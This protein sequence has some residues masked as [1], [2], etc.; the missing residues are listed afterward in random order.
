MD[1][2]QILDNGILEQY[3]LGELN[4]SE[5]VRIEAAIRRYPDLK[6]AL[7]ELESS[8]EELALENAIEVPDE[9]KI[10]LLNQIKRAHSDI[11][12][13]PQSNNKGFYLSIAASAAAILCIASIYLLVQVN[14]TNK[15]LEIAQENNIELNDN[16][17]SLNEQLVETSKWFEA[18]NDPDSEK[19]ILKGNSLMPNGIIISYVNN[20]KKSILINTEQ[21]PKL[22]AEHDYQMWADVDGAM[23]DMG[24]INKEGSML[25][26]NYIDNAK[27]LNITI[28]PA[29]GNDHPTVSQ[30]VTN[31]YLR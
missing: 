18:I 12:A 20:A 13:L 4:M 21:L 28:E 7:E 25:V 6:K 30:L 19:Y 5:K 24:V 10:E 15:A 8:L 26:M 2:S 9:V 1:K 16:F 17:K 11:I 23:I 22:D 31:V 29:G 3:V 14:S 27:S